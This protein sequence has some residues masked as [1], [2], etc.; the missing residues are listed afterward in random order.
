MPRVIRGGL[1]QK[2]Y[3][4]SESL[5]GESSLLS[6]ASGLT[7]SLSQ[8]RNKRVKTAHNVFGLRQSL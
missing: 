1:H 2:Y 5:R 7:V 4:W 6:L 8:K 3:L